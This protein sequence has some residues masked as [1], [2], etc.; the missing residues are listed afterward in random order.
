VEV[1]ADPEMSPRRTDYPTARLRLT[2]RDGRVLE[3]TTTVVRGDAA[4]PVPA[5]EVVTKF[6]T[7][8]SPV[9]GD[10]RAR[11]VVETIHEVDTLKDV[12]DLTALLVPA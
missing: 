12:R 11:Q 4:N 10:P 7:L 6:L 3:E 1:S 8:V 5:E 2:L 9:L